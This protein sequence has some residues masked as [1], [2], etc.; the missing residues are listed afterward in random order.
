MEL[1]DKIVEALATIPGTRVRHLKPVRDRWLVYAV[2]KAF[3]DLPHLDRQKMI[4]AALTGPQSQLTTG[5][6]RSIALVVTYSPRELRGR[7]AELRA[8]R[9]RRLKHK[10]AEPTP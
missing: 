7:L 9:A 1:K 4:D 8:N 10:P 6:Y 3:T 5:E 2:S